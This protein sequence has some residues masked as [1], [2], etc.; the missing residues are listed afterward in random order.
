MWAFPP[1]CHLGNICVHVHTDT[2]THTERGRNR[3]RETETQRGRKRERQGGGGNP[4]LLAMA[5]LIARTAN[6]FF[7]RTNIDSKLITRVYIGNLYMGNL[8]T[9]T[10][11]LTH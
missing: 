4:L 3:D 7:L 8:T 6:S 11:K 2:H 9:L 5:I 10:V 1:A